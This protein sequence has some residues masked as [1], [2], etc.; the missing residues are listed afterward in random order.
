M[1]N[2]NYIDMWWAFNRALNSDP[3]RRRD[4]TREPIVKGLETG[5]INSFPADKEIAGIR[6]D[7]S[8]RGVHVG[9]YA[10]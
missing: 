3:L 8:Q 2:Y 5:L 4:C 9:F 6:L 7:S 1:Y 10:E